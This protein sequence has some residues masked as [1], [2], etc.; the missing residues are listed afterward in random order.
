V[1]KKIEELRQHI[2]KLEDELEAEFEDA[3]VAL[4]VHIENGRAVFRE[5][6]L[7]RHS[8]LRTSLLKYVSGAKLLTILTA[9]AIYAVFVPLALLD[10]F[11]SIYQLICF[12]V[13]GIKKVRR[14]NHIVFDRH[15]L[16]YLN[17]IEKINCVYCSYA[18]GVLSYVV[19]VA[20]DT[21]KYWCP[22]KHARRIPNPHGSYHS[23]ADYGDA[24]GYKDR[25]A[26]C[27][28]SYK[29]IDGST[30]E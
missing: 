20:S 8:E 12:P 29:K 14:S 27:H 9:P 7:Q 10:L 28:R 11:V 2:Q 1:L 15:R 22:I 26:R 3:R 30:Q 21:E 17:G 6:V 25:V 23:F 13:Y 24:E 16:K 18:N 5:E 19:A 4:G